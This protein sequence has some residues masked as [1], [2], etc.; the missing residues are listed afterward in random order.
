MLRRFSKLAAIVAVSLG[1]WFAWENWPHSFMRNPFPS[2]P[3]TRPFGMAPAAFN[4]FVRAC[5][6]ARIHPHRIGQ[7]IGDH[8]LSVGYHKRDGAVWYRGGKIDYSA[9]IDISTR[10]LNRVQITRF[11]ETLAE[12]GFAAYYREGAKWRGNEHIHAI[13]APLRMKPQL[14]KQ[15]REWETARRRAKLPFYSWQKRWRLNWLP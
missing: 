14:Q 3:L 8:P 15:V 5:N 1:A 12:Q 11:L 4:G 2:Q 7:T 6:N 10:D 13:Y 9:A